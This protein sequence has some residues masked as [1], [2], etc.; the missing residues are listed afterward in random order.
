V[1][2]YKIFFVANVVVGL[3]SSTYE[4]KRV[5]NTKQIIAQRG[6]CFLVFWKKRKNS[7]NGKNAEY[8]AI[9]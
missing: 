3:Y 7:N 2:P 1:K 8:L 6:P 9:L 4:L 5:R